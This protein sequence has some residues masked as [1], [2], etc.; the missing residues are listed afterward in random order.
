M[1]PASTADRPQAPVVT[2]CLSVARGAA[3]I[4]SGGAHD[5][6]RGPLGDLR[7]RFARCVVAVRWVPSALGSAPAETRIGADPA[8]R[9]RHVASVIGAAGV[10]DGPGW[11]ACSA[12]PCRPSSFPQ[13]ARAPPQTV[14]AL[15]EGTSGGL[16]RHTIRTP[17]ARAW[18]H[19]RKSAQSIGPCVVRVLALSIRW[20]KRLGEQDRSMDEVPCARGNV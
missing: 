1:G 18:L 9:S 19:S 12:H 14:R 7:T 17:R 10:Q 3:T 11:R 8:L 20:I 13:R 15:S 16:A 4:A 6:A 2:D 5:L